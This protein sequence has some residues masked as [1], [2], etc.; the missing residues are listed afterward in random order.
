M[1]KKKA[2]I[3]GVDPGSTSAVAAVTLDGE[4]ELLESGKNFPPSEIIERI[5][6]VG[7]PVVVA[8]DKGKTPSTVEDIATSLGAEIFEPEEDLD[9]ERKRELG[10]GTNSHEK[11]AAASAMYAYNSLQREIKKIEK[12]EDRL[13]I[14]RPQVA[15]RYFSDKPL[16]PE[17]EGETE[18]EDEAVEDV[19]TENERDREKERLRR[20]VENLEEQVESLKSELGEEKSEKQKLRQKY[21]D[22]KEDKRDEIV[23]DQEIKKREGIIKEKNREIEELEDELENAEIREEQYR[24][25]I[26]MLKDEAEIVPIINERTEE[27]PDKAVTRSEEV[28]EKL[29]KRGFNVHHVDNVEGVELA[30]HHVVEEFPETAENFK[31]IIQE[32]RESR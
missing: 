30:Y 22:L 32:Y 21:E 11:D 1:S 13:E 8:S 24:E 3:I 18:V 15:K 31:E 7:R 29:Q 25:A 10:K 14:E 17:D 12:Y 28:E 9:S 23:K 6:K 19:Q 26:S 2:L 16:E 27:I 4:I 5:V 20:K